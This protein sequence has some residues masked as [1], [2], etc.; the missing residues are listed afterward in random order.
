MA[1]PPSPFDS[2]APPSTPLGL[3][4]RVWVGCLGGALVS[5]AGMWWVIGVQARPGGVD[6][7]TL[8]AWLASVAFLG[9]VVG[10]WLAIWL[11]HR[12]IRHLDGL[13]AGLETGDISE[14]RG[15]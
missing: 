7:A 4:M 11:S 3:R 9:V 6:A 8:V 5:A 2:P 1:T 14:L 10:A 15:L 12:L 13:N